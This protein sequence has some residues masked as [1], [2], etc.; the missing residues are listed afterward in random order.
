MPFLKKYS[1]LQAFKKMR[2]W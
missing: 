2:K 1:I